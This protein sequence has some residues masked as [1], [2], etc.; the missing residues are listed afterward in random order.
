MQITKLRLY[1]FLIYFL[2]N[3]FQEKIIRNVVYLL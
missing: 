3:A 1:L 2:I